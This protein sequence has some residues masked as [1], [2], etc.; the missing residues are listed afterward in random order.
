MLFLTRWFGV[1]GSDEDRSPDRERSDIKEITPRECFV[2]LQ[3]HL[4][5]AFVVD[6]NLLRETLFPRRLGEATDREA[7]GFARPHSM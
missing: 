3:N 4:Q 1:T 2:V 7:V 6:R 5:A